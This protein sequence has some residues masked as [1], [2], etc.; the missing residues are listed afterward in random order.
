MKPHSHSVNARLDLLQHGGLNDRLPAK[1]AC[2]CDTKPVT[3][4]ETRKPVARG[5]L[6]N[7][8]HQ[9]DSTLLY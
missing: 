8:A 2:R 7:T 4:L 5:A 9:V 1:N 3:E 6:E